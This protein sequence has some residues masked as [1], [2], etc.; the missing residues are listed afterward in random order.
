MLQAMQFNTILLPT[1]FSETADHAEA[2][3]IAI[4]RRHRSRLE[5]F[6]VVEP[7]GEPP[8]NMMAVVREYLE[9]LEREAEETLATKAE[10]IRAAGIDVSYSKAHHVP[11]F[12][13]IRDKV[14]ST[15]PDLVVIGTHGRRGFQHLVLGSVAEKL[16]R[17][18]PA[19]VLSVGGNT[20][21]ISGDRDLA[22]ILVPVDFSDPSSHALEAAYSLLADDGVLSLLH[23][24]HSP[25]RPSFYPNPFAPSQTDAPLTS[26]VRRHLTNWIG[27]RRG[28]PLIRTGEPADQI[29]EAREETEAEL[30]VMGTR[31]LTGLSH[32]LLGSVTDK[33][34][35]RS[36]VAVLTVH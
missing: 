22:R 4:A 29:L 13:A 5:L 17:S 8:Q 7:H 9:K 32:L 11:P 15:N 3:A 18:V 10:A 27:D 36:P 34:V 31:G 19:T 16:L 14:A 33:V 12:D 28:E 24:V 2:Q 6:H 26:D 35:R 25:A 23:V 1:D 30:I 20:P 21:L